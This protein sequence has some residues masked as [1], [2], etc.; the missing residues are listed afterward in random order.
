MRVNSDDII[1]EAVISKAAKENIDFL[2]DYGGNDPFTETEDFEK[3]MDDVYSS[4]MKAIKT[5]KS[6]RK[7]LCKAAVIAAVLVALLLAAAFSV[8]AVKI[9]LY[10][11]WTNIQGDIM[12]VNINSASL[13]DQYLGISNFEKKDK[14]LIPAW[15]PYGTELLKIEDTARRLTLCYIYQDQSINFKQEILSNDIL[16]IDEQYFLERSEYEGKE[17][18][19]NGLTVNI[20]KIKGDLEKDIYMAEWQDNEISYSLKVYD[21]ELL[22]KSILSSIK[23][24]R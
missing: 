16:G 10:K 22:L 11:T 19:I 23:P 14:I 20:I 3:M 1:F 8:S 24:L 5:E 2:S 15:L 7:V 21:S 6:K 13:T 9:F 4:I 18:E 12:N 17:I